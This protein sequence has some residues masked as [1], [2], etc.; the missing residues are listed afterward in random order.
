MLY[1]LE[2]REAPLP[3]LLVE[4]SEIVSELHK[5]IRVDFGWWSWG[6][7]FPNDTWLSDSSDSGSSSGCI[8]AFFCYSPFFLRLRLWLWLWLWF[9]CR[10][11]CRFDFSHLPFYLPNT[12]VADQ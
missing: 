9:D 5:Q 8:I 12:R 2:G 6:E 4:G 1:N 3:R 11:D 7:F 10:F